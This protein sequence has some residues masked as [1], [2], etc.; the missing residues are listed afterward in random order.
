MAETEEQMRPRNRNKP[1][2]SDIESLETYADRRDQ[3]SVA[4]P[5][6]VG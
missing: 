6:E 4:G 2:G 3:G 1:R 5:G